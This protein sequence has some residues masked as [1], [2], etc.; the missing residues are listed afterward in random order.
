MKVKVFSVIQWLD[1]ALQ[2]KRNVVGYVNH[3]S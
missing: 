2:K 1:L 3:L